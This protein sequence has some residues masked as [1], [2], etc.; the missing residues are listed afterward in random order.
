MNRGLILEADSAKTCREL[1][2][3]RIGKY[4]FHFGR[5]GRRE[6]GAMP[7]LALRCPNGILGELACLLH[8]RRLT[9]EAIR[10]GR[11]HVVRHILLHLFDLGFSL[12]VFDEQRTDSILAESHVTPFIR[13]RAGQRLGKLGIRIDIGRL[14]HLE[15]AECQ[16]LQHDPLPHHAR[17]EIAL[18]DF[19]EKDLGEFHEM[20]IRVTF[21]DVLELVLLDTQVV[22][23]LG[24]DLDVACLVEGVCV[25]RKRLLG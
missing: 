19:F 11:E 5:I 7:D 16:T 1:L 13:D 8:D 17:N 15:D 20:R 10:E 24:K 6:I 4:G 3:H 23:S 2:E 25:A 18:V 14:E 21:D 22:E 9:T 12:R